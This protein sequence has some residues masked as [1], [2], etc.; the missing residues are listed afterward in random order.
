VDPVTLAI[1]KNDA[2]SRYVSTNLHGAV[3]DGTTND[4]TVIAAVLAA[5][6]AGSILDL[7]GKTYLL[8]TTLS[9]NKKITIRNGTLTAAFDVCRFHRRAVCDLPRCDVF[10]NRLTAC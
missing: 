3:G 2:A 5:A 1:A 8:G 9:I 4:Y 10:P 6:P 7:G